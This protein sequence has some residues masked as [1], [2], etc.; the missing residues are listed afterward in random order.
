MRP[1]QPDRNGGQTTAQHA[2]TP[3]DRYRA[4]E[5][6]R[7]L[8]EVVQVAQLGTLSAWLVGAPLEEVDAGTAYCPRCQSG[9]HRWMLHGPAATTRDG[10]TWACGCGARGTA[11]SLEQQVLA[12]PAALVRIEDFLRGPTMPKD[13]NVN[14][15]RRNLGDQ[16]GI[17]RDRTVPG[18]N[19][20]GGLTQQITRLQQ[21]VRSMPTP[22]SMRRVGDLTVTS[23]SVAPVNASNTEGLVQVTGLHVVTA[24]ATIAATGGTWVSIDLS[25]AGA[26]SERVDYRPLYIGADVEG[27]TIYATGT[28]WCTEGAS[29]SSAIDGATVTAHALTYS[30]VG[31]L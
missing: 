14:V 11:Y 13:G 7:Q 4:G 2:R 16:L 19:A 25:G 30:H 15:R 10:I 22:G 6:R 20:G 12:S 31:V 17:G 18:A 23:Y 3:Q 24:Q 5:F 29:L 27:L 26:G 21:Q 1:T 8:R 9:G 28:A